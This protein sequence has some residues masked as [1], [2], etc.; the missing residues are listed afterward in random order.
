MEK[1]FHLGGDE[2]LMDRPG[3]ND[4]W[5]GADMIL[6]FQSLALTDNEV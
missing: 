1:E 3:G 6:S 4:Q 5:A 2:G